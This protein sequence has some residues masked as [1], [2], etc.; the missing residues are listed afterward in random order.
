M[1]IEI[2]Q[3]KNAAL[4]AAAL[5]VDEAG[6]R[7]G[8]I[9]A[10]EINLFTEKATMLLN[11]KKCTAQE[12]AAIFVLQEC[13][14]TTVE[15]DMFAKVDSLHKAKNS[16]EVLA[17]EFG[18]LSQ[19]ELE[20]KYRDIKIKISSN[21][22]RIET[23]EQRLAQKEITSEQYYND[24]G[25]YKFDKTLGKFGV[26]TMGVGIGVAL[27]GGGILAETI[28][29]AC[30]VIGSLGVAAVVGVGCLIVDMVREF[31]HQDSEC[32]KGQEEIREAYKEGYK[33]AIEENEKL[34]PQLE[35]LEKLL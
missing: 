17:T 21:N 22:S 29:G 15:S 9:D 30:I 10:S 14:K 35:E 19:E 26:N 16:E 4:K 8:F 1:S 7:N 34:K 20:D 33:Y 5:E 6:K 31:M 2:V 32:A 18:K 28:V 12:F 25:Q 13:D 3:I 27:L 11:D 23:F 24:I